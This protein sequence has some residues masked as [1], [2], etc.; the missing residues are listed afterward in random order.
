MFV[1]VLDTETFRLRYASAGH[2]TAYRA[3]QRWRHP[4]AVTGPVL[5]VMEEPF[6]AENLDLAPGETLVLATDGL[7]EVR[8]K[9]GVQLSEQGAIGLI[10][11][12]SVPAQR[13]ADELVAKVRELSGDQ[14]RDDLAILAIRILGPGSPCLSCSRFLPLQSSPLRRTRG[15]IAKCMPGTASCSTERPRIRRC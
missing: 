8:N 3:P 7:T 9:A 6:T 11:H 2:D 10:E 5:G 4:L 1:G 13:L 14:V 15:P 12:A